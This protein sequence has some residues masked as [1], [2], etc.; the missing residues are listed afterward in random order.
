MPG[1][2]LLTGRGCRGMHY[3]VTGD[4][5]FLGSAFIKFASNANKKCFVLG[6]DLADETLLKQNYDLP[7]IIIHFAGN[8]NNDPDLSIRNNIIVTSQI[9]RLAQ[10]ANCKGVVYI[11]SI[12][13]VGPVNSKIDAGTEKHPASNYGKSKDVSED[14][15]SSFISRHVIVRPTNIFDGRKTGVLAH[16]YEV[17]ENGTEYE[18]WEESLRSKRDYICLDDVTECIFAIAEKM[19]N[20]AEGLPKII[21]LGSGKSYSMYELIRLVED[22]GGKKIKKKVV[23]NPDFAAYDLFVEDDAVESLLKR[24]PVTVEE[25][26]TGIRQE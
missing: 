24:A 10:N 11:S 14:I 23:S 21:N 2:V 12:A 5:G 1:N 8:K 15:V 17:L 26:I 6:C 13:S 19:E 20:G 25:A 7:F 4:R 18:A 9:A 3:L 16:L 22:K